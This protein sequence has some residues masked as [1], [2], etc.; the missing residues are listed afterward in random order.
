MF[1]FKKYHVVII[2][3]SIV[4]LTEYH[5]G[6]LHHFVN[7][8]RDQ[9]LQGSA[10]STAF[11]LENRRNIHRTEDMF[12]KTDGRHLDSASARGANQ[13]Q[14]LKKMKGLL[15]ENTTCEQVNCT[16][17][18]TLWKM[19]H[20]YALFHAEGVKLI[21]QGQST[22]VRTLT[23]Y[24]G[25][26]LNSCGGLGF[27]FR[28]MTFAWIIGMLTGRVVLFKW[29]RESTESRHLLSN[30]INWR[31][32]SNYK[33][34]GTVINNGNF[35][36]IEYD[37][38]KYERLL[39]K[40][41]MGDVNHIQM[42]YNS[43][44]Q[45]NQFIYNYSLFSSAYYGTSLP[46]ISVSSIPH[47]FNRNAV[48]SVGIISMFR[49]SEN[50]KSYISHVQTQL[51]EVTLGH[52]YVALHIRTGKFDG[53]NEALYHKRMSADII[54]WKIA[55]KCALK[56]ADKHIGPNSVVM[57]V[58]DSAE[59]KRWVAQEY[60]RVRTL[61][62]KIVHIDRS[63][64]YDEEGMLGV[65]QDITIMAQALVLVK[66]WSSFPDI[67]I[68]MCGMPSSRIVNYATC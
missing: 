37:I 26:D 29:S 63:S 36:D 3:F 28:G 42:H 35:K 9:W 33:L 34:E 56:Q 67:P 50:L 23:W 51:H 59:A 21:R 25:R 39:M 45:L 4:L 68:A 2:I 49:F 38:S 7:T 27:R 60:K 55:V 17:L 32:L 61:D 24:C 6:V 14:C 31:Y 40:A 18:A 30:M 11:K 57:V 19:A 13:G 46:G 48:L 54:S 16:S 47:T 20:A 64:K 5:T 12:D 44:S 15:C 65:W 52:H 58:S 62:T 53:R 10:F 22:S 43:V 41:L 1:R 8:L 66:K